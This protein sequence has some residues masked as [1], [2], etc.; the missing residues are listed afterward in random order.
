M[1]VTQLAAASPDTVLAR[2]DYATVRA[3][4][5]TTIR[6][7][8]NDAAL[9]GANLTLLG[10]I[11]DAKAPGQLKVYNAGATDATAGIWERHTSAAMRS[12]ISR[13]RVLRRP[14]K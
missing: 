12:A 6:V 5:A 7:L 9:S 13:R 4:D 11:A 14:P 8:E 10:N 3:G 1:S 2:A